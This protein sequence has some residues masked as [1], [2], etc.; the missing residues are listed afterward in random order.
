MLLLQ[1]GKFTF[2]WILVYLA[3]LLIFNKGVIVALFFRRF[4]ATG[5]PKFFIKQYMASSL[6]KF[7]AIVLVSAGVFYLVEK[8]KIPV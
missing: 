3:L 8:G 6:I 7:T 1:Y 2:I 4:K 5:M